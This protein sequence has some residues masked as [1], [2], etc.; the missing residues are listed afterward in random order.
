[1]DLEISLHVIEGCLCL[2]T[3]FW[4]KMS[5]SKMIRMQPFKSI[6]LFTI[7]ITVLGGI[8]LW[9]YDVVVLFIDM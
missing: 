9:V 6:A 4:C 2:F 1:M 7:L 8:A 5:D 3:F